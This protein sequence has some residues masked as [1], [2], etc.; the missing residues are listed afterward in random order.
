[1]LSEN[2]NINFLP[3]FEPWENYKTD[4]LEAIVKGWML[5]LSRA[6]WAQWHE[7]GQKCIAEIGAELDKRSLEDI[8]F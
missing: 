5:I 7:Y 2:I 1:M 4:Q 8:P 3:T 6:A